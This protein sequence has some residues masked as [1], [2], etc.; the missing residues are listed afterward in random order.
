MISLTIDHSTL[1]D[2]FGASFSALTNPTDAK[3]DGACSNAE[4]VVAAHTA[5]AVDT[6]NDKEAYLCAMV[7]LNLIA[8]GRWL[9][10]GTAD[11]ITNNA[12]AKAYS[13]KPPVWTKEVEA[14]ALTVYPSYKASRKPGIYIEEVDF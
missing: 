10:R 2:F 11:S 7:A 6:S 5:Q 13:P 12:E 3:A 8:I 9:D 4:V 14:L 1:E